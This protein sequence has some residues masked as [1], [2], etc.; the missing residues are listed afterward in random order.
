MDKE[1]TTE[2]QDAI[3]AGERALRSLQNAKDYLRSAGNWGIVDLIGGGTI[4]SLIKHSK[5]S[6]ARDEMQRAS[7]DLVKF[8]DELKDLD[9]QGDELRFTN[10]FSLIDM[11]CDN[12]VADFVVQFRINNT[13]DQVE[14]TI[15]QVNTIL[16]ELKDI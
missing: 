2:K 15:W 10:L 14:Q 4:T 11:F 1:F 7:D 5:M 9:I 13:K 3:E 6:H 8:A 16:N 12:F